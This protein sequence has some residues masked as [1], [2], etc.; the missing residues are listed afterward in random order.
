[1]ASKIGVSRKAVYEYEREQMGATLATVA[2]I[3]EVIK[4][5]VLTGI[6]IFAWTPFVATDFKPPT[7]EVARQ[8]HNKLREIGCKAMGFN[9]APIDVHMHDADVGFLTNEHLRDAEL[10]RKVDNAVHVGKILGMAPILVTKERCHLE[11]DITTIKIDEISCIK[12]KRDLESLLRID[13][14][15]SN[16]N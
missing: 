7:S 16:D 5:N 12:K 11:N 9:Y 1:L 6:N 4:A 13:L 8:L 15:K 10:E 2:K 3:E 14:E